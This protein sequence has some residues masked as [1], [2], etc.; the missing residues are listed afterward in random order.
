MQLCA[1]YLLPAKVIQCW[2]HYN[3]IEREAFGILHSL[4]KSHHYWFAKEVC[5]IIDYKPMVAIIKKAVAMLPQHSQHIMLHSHHHH[6]IQTGP[7]PIHIR[8]AIPKQPHR[9]RNQEIAGM[10]V[11]VHIISTSVHTILHFDRGHTGVNLTG[12]RHTKAELIHNTGLATQKRGGGT[13]C[14]EVFAS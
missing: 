8:L 1:K 13:K 5:V 7:R 12:C 4:E 9:N 10:S 11:N 6:F 14:E 2:M 3:N